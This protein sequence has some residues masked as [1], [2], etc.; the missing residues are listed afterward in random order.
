MVPRRF[1]DFVSPLR[2]CSPTF[3]GWGELAY[4]QRSRPSSVPFET[5]VHCVARKRA[6]CV[7]L[8]ELCSAI[9][10][11]CCQPLTIQILGWMALSTLAIYP[12]MGRYAGAVERG[13]QL[14]GRNSDGCHGSIAQQE[15]VRH[16]K[17]GKEATP[18][19]HCMDR[20]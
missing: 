15:V 8:G 6:A 7:V 20:I 14:N 13:V 10:V 16:L 3:S 18:L 19:V 2:N 12:V 17:R 5:R 9:G 4:P 1:S 11:G